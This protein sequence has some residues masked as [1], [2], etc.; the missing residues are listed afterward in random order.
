MNASMSASLVEQHPHRCQIV[1]CK[2][3]VA[4]PKELLSV[5]TCPQMPLQ[6]QHHSKLFLQSKLLRKLTTFLRMTVW[7][8]SMIL[9]TY[10]YA[11]DLVTTAHSATLH[12]FFCRLQA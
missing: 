2:I 3:T 8:G 7:T 10:W 6:A 4:R 9:K 12:A 11:A 1:M 5:Q